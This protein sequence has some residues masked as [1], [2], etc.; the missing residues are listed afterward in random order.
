MRA[1]VAIL[2]CLAVLVGSAVAVAASIDPSEAQQRARLVKALMAEANG[3][4]CGCTAA[5]RAKDRV[6]SRDTADGASAK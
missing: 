4:D 2:V 1:L 3:T 6:A 5:I